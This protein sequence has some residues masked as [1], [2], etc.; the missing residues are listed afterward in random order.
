[1]FLTAHFPVG[2]VSDGWKLYCAFLCV[3][4][5]RF[6]H[7]GL[8]RYIHLGVSV[9]VFWSCSLVRVITAWCLGGKQSANKSLGEGNKGRLGEVLTSLYCAI[10]KVA[11]SPLWNTS[12][13]ANSLT[14]I[15]KK[16]TYLTIHCKDGLC[17]SQSGQKVP[18][19]LNR[20]P[21][22]MHLEVWWDMDRK[23]KLV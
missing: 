3:T 12:H 13:K 19:S 22:H 16:K 4:S 21:Y 2:A 14:L 5:V 6:T 7:E 11:V 8:S 9:S 10:I 17:V 1:M 18:C 23:L 20:A 15:L